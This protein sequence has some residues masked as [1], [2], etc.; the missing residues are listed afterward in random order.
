MWS[1]LPRQAGAHG[2]LAARGGH[3]PRIVK[4]TVMTMLRLGPQRCALFAEA[5]RELANLVAAALVLGQ[6][7]TQERVSPS[8]LLGGIAAWLLLLGLALT[9]APENANG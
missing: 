2:K 5:F 7:V 3:A 1:K 9:F 6:L 8:L 4:C